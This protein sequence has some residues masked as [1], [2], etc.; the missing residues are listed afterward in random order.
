MPGHRHKVYTGR[1]SAWDGSPEKGVPVNPIEDERAAGVGLADLV[2]EEPQREGG[3][4]APVLALVTG[5]AR[6]LGARF[7][8]ALV[9]EGFDVAF[10]YHQSRDAAH[11]LVESLEE[12]FD[13]DIAAFEADL[14]RPTDC[15]ELVAAVEAEMG[16]IGLLV[17]NAGVL[18]PASLDSASAAD[19][20]R[21][22]ETNLR[23]PYLLSIE[24][25]RRMVSR[26]GGAIINIASTGAL[27]P[28]LHHLSYSI[29]KAGVVMLTHALAL[30]LAPHVTVNAIA[31][32]TIWLEGEDQAAGKPAPER[33]PLGE[34]GDPEDVEDALVYLASAPY[35][36]GQVLG[37]DG[38]W[39]LRS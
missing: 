8:R 5:G 32:G 3:D 39:R 26:R 12:E 19:L 36:T 10:T 14:R 16:P 34:W 25:G 30:A 24:C 18:V 20:D 37:V 4:E 1:T 23:A 29:T 27:R 33:I 2:E 35:V 21:C 13:S 7:V 28:Y 38:G 9:R 15:T 22:Y 17:N 6:R 31:P 11:Q